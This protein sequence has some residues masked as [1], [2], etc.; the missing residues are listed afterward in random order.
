LLVALLVSW[1]LEKELAL[2]RGMAR[3]LRSRG[4]VLDDE[5]LTQFVTTEGRRYVPADSPYEFTFGVLAPSA[6]A[7]STGEPLFFPGGFVFV[8]PS[9][10]L[11]ARDQREFGAKLAHAVVHVARGHGFRQ[12]PIRAWLSPETFPKAWTQHEAATDLIVERLLE[13]TPARS[14]DG[15]RRAQDR[16]R[17]WIP[18]R[19]SPS[20]LRR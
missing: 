4:Q 6:P 5:E 18:T 7:P 3:D 2:G 12:G 11:A 8:H 19:K 20:L 15:F 1:E 13:E 16:I 9:Q 10:I 17:Q 14:D